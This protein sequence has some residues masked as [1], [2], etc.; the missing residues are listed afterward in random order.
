MKNIVFALCFTFFSCSY[1]HS[2]SQTYLS[3][4][5]A[6]SG[7]LASVNFE[8]FFY[9]KNNL[10]LYHRTGFSLVPVDKNNG[11]V[12]IFPLMLHAV[13]GRT[14]YKLDIGLGQTISVTTKGSAFVLMPLSFGC[15]LQPLGK[16][17]YF[18]LAY[19]PI[20]SY[21]LDFQWQHWGGITCGIAL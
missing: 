11:W 10:A 12:L 13:Y 5:L 16:S 3:I 21:L 15:R 2:Q 6:G 7:G 18:R 8:R 1:V 4:E 9:Q 19:T 14:K 17:Y 20:V